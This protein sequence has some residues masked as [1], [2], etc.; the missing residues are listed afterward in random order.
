MHAAAPGAL[1]TEPLSHDDIRA[2]RLAY[3][4]NMTLVDRK[5]GTIVDM[6][7][8][9]GTYDNT[10]ILFTTDHGDYLGD[11][12]LNGKGQNVPE[13]LMRVPFLVKPPSGHV[14]GK[15]ESA[16][17]SSV[18]IAATV[19]HAAGAEVPTGMSSRDLSAYWQSADDLDDRDLLY[20]EAGGIRVLRNRRW[21]Y[22]HY[23]NRD[24]GE[25][26]DL[27]ND[28]WETSNL[29]DAPDQDQRK[30]AFCRQLVDALISLSPRSHVP[31]NRNAPEL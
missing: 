19:L 25:L 9:Q 3:Y 1:P 29:W 7:K 26:Y 22:C 6:L 2:Q 15:T 27:Q 14:K 11:F 28:P 24:Y 21:K 20:M 8:Q 31:W 13:V 12:C 17:I 30:A 4:A 10:L 18:D 23:A 5:I 16:L